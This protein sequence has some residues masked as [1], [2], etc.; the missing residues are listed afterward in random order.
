LDGVAASK[1]RLRPATISPGVD[2]P[3]FI[4]DGGLIAR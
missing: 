2:S 3:H 4:I 1:L